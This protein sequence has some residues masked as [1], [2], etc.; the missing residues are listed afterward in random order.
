MTEEI[1]KEQTKQEVGPSYSWYR[2]KKMV[3]MI[4]LVV[5]VVLQIFAFLQVPFMSTINA[6]TIGLLL[7]F[8]NPLFYLFVAYISLVM[9]FGEK[10]RLPKWVKL[11][12]LTYWIVAISI[13]FI[14]AS[15]G[16]Y[17]TVSDGWTAIGAEPW[18]SFNVWFDKF[19]SQ[20]WWAPAQTDGGVIGVFLY[21]LF[22]SATS[23]IGALIIAIAALVLTVSLV[24]S[25]SFI[26]LYKQIHEK[27]KKTLESTE[28]HDDLLPEKK[29]D[30]KI[31]PIEIK[32]DKPIESVVI[33]PKPTPKVEIKK[34]PEVKPAVK[35]VDANDFPFE[36]PF[37]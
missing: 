8:Y 27:R 12:K 24:A 2:D 25:G 11:T 15:T 17:Q 29:E 34:E 18:G 26:G 16:Y 31:E 32:Q 21:S 23:G 13:V 3:G 10:V 7:G 20:P 4:L 36:D 19:T 35:Q 5:T 14:G 1:K 9:I 37:A 6:Y 33:P 28:V 30:K 22:A